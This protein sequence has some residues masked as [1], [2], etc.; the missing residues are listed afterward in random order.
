MTSVKSSLLLCLFPFLCFCQQK[1]QQ[2]DSLFTALNR[3]DQFNGTVLIAEKGKVILEKG[4]GYSNEETKQLN[5]PETIFDLA[6]CSK[7]FTAAAIVLLK[8]QG[9]L[10]METILTNSY[11]SWPHG[12][13]LPYPICYTIPVAYPN[14]FPVRQRSRATAISL[15]MT[16]CSLFMLQ[17]GIPCYLLPEAGTGTVILTTCCWLLSLKGSPEMVTKGRR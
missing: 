16:M 13:M 8:R 10:I 5:G 15:P 1:K 4:Y 3:Q 7:Q 2:L 12:R 17:P 9:K 11:R 6:S 14:S